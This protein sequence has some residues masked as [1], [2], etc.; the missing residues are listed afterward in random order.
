VEQNLVFYL[1]KI[2]VKIDIKGIE[3]EGVVDTDT[4]Q[5]KSIL[6]ILGSIENTSQQISKQT[7]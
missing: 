2:L 5:K 1:N 3:R 7:T 6:G 4:P